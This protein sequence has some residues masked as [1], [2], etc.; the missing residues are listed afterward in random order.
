MKTAIFS[1]LFLLPIQLY[2]SDDYSLFSPQETY[3]DTIIRTEIKKSKAHPK[4]SCH[5]QLH[6]LSNQE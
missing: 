3:V 6:L 5:N 2:A 1:W 4:A